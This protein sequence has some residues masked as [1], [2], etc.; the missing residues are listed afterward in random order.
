MGKEGFGDDRPFIIS[1]GKVKTAT[2]LQLVATEFLIVE[3]IIK[4]QEALFF[5]FFCFLL[6]IGS[7]KNS[8]F[9]WILFENTFLED[10]SSEGCKEWTNEPGSGR[11]L[12]DIVN[13][14]F[15][16]WLGKA[17]IGNQ[18]SKSSKDPKRLKCTLDFSDIDVNKIE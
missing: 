6:A 3:S 14:V 5:F 4:T 15:S 16:S 18:R 8:R 17:C 13:Q 2:H 12:N 11:I 9:L 7:F 10:K 1:T